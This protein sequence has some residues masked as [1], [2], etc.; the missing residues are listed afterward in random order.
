MIALLFKHVATLDEETWT[1]CAKV[2]TFTVI[3]GMVTLNPYEALLLSVSI[4]LS[5]SN[6]GDSC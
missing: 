5:R 2:S 1:W 4:S 6:T 3:I